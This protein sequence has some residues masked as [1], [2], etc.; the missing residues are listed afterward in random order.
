MFLKSSELSLLGTLASRKLNNSLPGNAIKGLQ[1][2]PIPTSEK[3]TSYNSIFIIDGDLSMDFVT[4]CQVYE[5]KRHQLWFD[6]RRHRPAHT[7]HD[8]GG[9]A[10]VYRLEQYELQF[11][12]CYRRPAWVDVMRQAGADTNWYTPASDSINWDSVLTFKSWS[13]RYHFQARLQLPPTHLLWEHQWESHD[14]MQ[15]EPLALACD[16]ANLFPPDLWGY[17]HRFYYQPAWCLVKGLINTACILH[18]PRETI[19]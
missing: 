18:E 7:S 5:L 9:I 19:L 13:P 2:L 1:S 4:D 11:D 12:P 17:V 10:Y 16:I 15:K 8:L 3:N 14:Y 6:F